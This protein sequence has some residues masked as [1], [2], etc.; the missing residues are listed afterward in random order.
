MAYVPNPRKVFQFSIILEG[1]DPFLCQEVEMPD[2]E[3]EAVEHGDTNHDIKTAG[4]VKVGMIKLKKLLVADAP[5]NLFFNWMKDCQN[6]FTGG[7]L[8]PYLYKRNAW[9]DEY[10]TDGTSLINSNFY[11][12]VWPTKRSAISLSRTASENTIEELELC[13]DRPDRL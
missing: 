1:L 10:A 7:G 9:I 13:V 8:T 12:G 5:D 11:E 3:V 6:V 2:I 4:R